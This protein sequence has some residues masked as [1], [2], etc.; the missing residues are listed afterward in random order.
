[1]IDESFDGALLLG[2]AEFVAERRVRIKLNDG[3][4]RNVRGNDVL[5]NTGTMPSVPAIVGLAEAVPLTSETLLHLDRIPEHL[6]V[7][8]G[9]YVGLKFAQTFSAFGSKVSVLHRRERL[10]PHEGP[11]IA[12]AVTEALQDAGV[13]FHLGAE[14]R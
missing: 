5:I 7:M 4:T 14:V 3:G 10:L 2:V 6:V 11:D 9:G 12:Q 8:G 13:D 1:M